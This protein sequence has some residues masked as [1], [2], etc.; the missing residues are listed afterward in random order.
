[1]LVRS[2]MLPKGWFKDVQLLNCTNNLDSHRNLLGQ[3]YQESGIFTA[4]SIVIFLG[5]VKIRTEWYSCPTWKPQSRI[6]GITVSFFP[7]LCTLSRMPWTSLAQ[8]RLMCSWV[9]LWVSYRRD[10]WLEK[11]S[12]TIRAPPALPEPT[13]T[14]VP[15]CHTRN[16]SLA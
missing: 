10:L 5:A 7:A 15:K 3:D 14:R 1:M 8:G 2:F 6:N 13:L 16:H 11:P 9:S 12:E 4:S